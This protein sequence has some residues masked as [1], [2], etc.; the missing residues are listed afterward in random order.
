[1]QPTVPKP[2]GFEIQKMGFRRGKRWLGS[3]MPPYSTKTNWMEKKIGCRRGKCEHHT[4]G[5]QK[6]PDGRARTHFASGVKNRKASKWVHPI[7]P[8][9]PSTIALI[10]PAPSTREERDPPVKIKSS[11]AP[12]AQQFKHQYRRCSNRV[13][14][15]SGSRQQRRR[16]Q[17]IGDR[18]HGIRDRV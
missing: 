7:L 10:C 16:G 18:G 1:M 5:Q 8:P 17:G 15:G 4:I 2:T 13:A 12:T 14:S 6:G 9:L 3:N 11:T